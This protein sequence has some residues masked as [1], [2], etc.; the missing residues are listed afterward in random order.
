MALESRAV[1]LIVESINGNCSLDA[2]RVTAYCDSSKQHKQVVNM[3]GEK[4]VCNV[5]LQITI[6]LT[7]AGLCDNDMSVHKH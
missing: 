5:F 6:T 3:R 7:A 4:Y 2:A 1:L